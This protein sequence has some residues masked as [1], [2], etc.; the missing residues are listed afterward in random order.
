MEHHAVNVGY[1]IQSFD[2]AALLV[3]ARVA[4]AGEDHRR[5]SAFV[6]DQVVFRQQPAAQAFEKVKQIALQSGQ[7]HLGLGVAESAV[8]FNHI[9]I[10]SHFDEAEEDDAFVWDAVFS[11]PFDGR[12]N[13]LVQ[14][15]L[16]EFFR[17]KGNRRNGAHAA[18]VGAGVT[19]TDALV[20]LR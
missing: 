16:L 7:D 11:E 20:V 10:A 4:F 6:C 9:R 17:Q 15:L 12:D 18:C 3:T 19:F 14:R 5:R 8:V 13:D 2:F 1:V